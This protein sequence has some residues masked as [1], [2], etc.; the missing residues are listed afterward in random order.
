LVTTESTDN[1]Q[2][3]TGPEIDP[4]VRSVVGRIVAAFAPSMVL[5]FGSH[6]RGDV[7]P[8]SDVDMLIVWRDNAPPPNPSSAI[9]R[10]LGRV[11]FPMDLLVVSP[12]DFARFRQWKG[13]VVYIAT[14]EGIVLHAV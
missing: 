14:H 7:R 11:G 5:L 13:H 1:E 6:A 2:P 8:D 9:R 10:A 4:R 3:P 12:E